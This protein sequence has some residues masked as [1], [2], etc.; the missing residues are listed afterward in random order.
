MF[1][2]RRYLELA[3][4][5]HGRLWRIAFWNLRERFRQ[6]AAE[7]VQQALLCAWEKRDEIE[8]VERWLAVVVKRVARHWRRTFVERGSEALDEHYELAS[9]ATPLDALLRAE[10]VT[11]IEQAV[12]KLS[13]AYRKNFA[14]W[15]ARDYRSNT[16]GEHCRASRVNAKLR[17]IAARMAA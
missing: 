3:I 7:V 6:D 14:D 9:Y 5:A 1:D 15:V 17:A 11:C 8:D 13:P 2:E 16:H 12:R 10:R 4:P